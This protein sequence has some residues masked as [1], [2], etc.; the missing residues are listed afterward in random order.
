MLVFLTSEKDNGGEGWPFCARTNDGGKTWQF[1]GWIGKQPPVDSYGYAIMPSTVRLGN[2]ALLSSIRRGGIF[3]GVKRWW[4][5]GFLSPDDG[6]S[7]YMLDEMNIDNSGNPASMITLGTAELPLPMDGDML[8]TVFVPEFLKTRDRLGARRLSCAMIV[9]VGTL[10]TQEPYNE[11][12]EKSLQY[13]ITWMHRVK[14]DIS[15]LPSGIQ[16]K[17]K[18]NN[19][20]LK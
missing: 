11:Q 17:V 13:T 14:N 7:W 5:E 12:M 19:R 3:D 9:I 15:P 10:A 20:L 4:I 18:R 8:P 2:G 16:V 1:Q 6:K